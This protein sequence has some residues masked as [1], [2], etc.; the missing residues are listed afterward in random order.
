M[1]KPLALDINWADFPGTGTIT[2]ANEHSGNYVFLPDINVTNAPDQ[3]VFN[4]QDAQLGYSSFS[5]IGIGGIGDTITLNYGTGYLSSENGPGDNFISQG[6]DNVD[7]NVFAG[8]GL[9]GE[10]TP[11]YTDAILVLGNPGNTEG[12][13][14]GPR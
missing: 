8:S 1:A 2:L 7:V 10:L 14:E 6:I 13:Q 4:F 12:P 9:T 5:I 11:V 3:G